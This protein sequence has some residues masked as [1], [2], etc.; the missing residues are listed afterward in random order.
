[1]LKTFSTGEI[2]FQIFFLFSI[3]LIA[4]MLR[5]VENFIQDKI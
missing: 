3:T 1:M 5:F 4:M 2:N